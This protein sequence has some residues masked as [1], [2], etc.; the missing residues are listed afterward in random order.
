MG[1]SLA[2]LYIVFANRQQ[3]DQEQDQD[4][5]PEQP[6]T[7]GT[8]VAEGNLKVLGALILKAAPMHEKLLEDQRKDKAEKV[9][10][11]G[12]NPG[13]ERPREKPL[14]Q[15][16]LAE[17]LRRSFRRR[18]HSSL[19]I[20]RC[21]SHS[22][23]EFHHTRHVAG[24]APALATTDTINLVGQ[25]QQQQHYSFP[26]PQT[27]AGLSL[28][29]H[30]NTALLLDSPDECTPPEY[31]YQHLSS[32]ATTNT[33]SSSSLESSYE[34]GELRDSQTSIYY[35]AC[36]K[37]SEMGSEMSTTVTSTNITELPG[38][39]LRR[40]LQS[41][42]SG[43]SDGAAA[44]P[45][46][47]PPANS[48]SRSCSLTSDSSSA[49]ITRLQNFLFK[50]SNE[51]SRSCQGHSND[52]FTASSFNSSSGEW[53][54]LG[55]HGAGGVHDLTTGSFP[56]EETPF[57]TDVE[58]TLPNESS[59]AGPYYQ[60]TLTSPNNP[61]LPEIT[62]RSYHSN[63]RNDEAMAE[64][65]GG[66][67][68]QEELQLDCNVTSVK[69]TGSGGSAASRCA[70]L[71]TPVYSRAG[72]QESS[73]SESIISGPA[74]PTPSPA[75]SSSS[76]PGRHRRKLFSL[77][78]PTRLQQHQTNAPTAAS[79]YQQQQQQQ[80]QKIEMSASPPEG[81]SQG[82]PMIRTLNPFLGNATSP[83]AVPSTDLRSKREE[84]LRATMKICLVVSPPAS[85]LQVSP[86]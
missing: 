2:A 14:K 66:G 30:I 73:F 13:K 51:S 40:Q 67:L 70:Q 29:G 77:N 22:E 65:G 43:R 48:S 58:A 24:G 72:S 21:E 78:S 54:Q 61:F 68:V 38:N 25:Q 52:G 64:V 16:K 74:G 26:T 62:A 63:Y 7:R 12:N 5:K 19:E 56:E 45:A 86:I 34:L 46:N 27:L 47:P 32:V 44:N 85:K 1:G 15:S 3:Q 18:E 41:Q 4:Q 53:E 55:V 49:R 80:Y 37:N 75:S 28:G 83:I 81:Q 42:S 6:Y 11:L 17:R 57:E 23:S 10:L 39:V 8:Q 59:D 33:N 36:P 79:L 9:Q 84:F 20:K 60:Y 76:T 35:W 50:N 71:P 82:T 69:Y 31:A